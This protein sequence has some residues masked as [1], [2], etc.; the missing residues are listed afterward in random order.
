MRGSISSNATDA[1]KWEATTVIRIAQTNRNAGSGS[2]FPAHSIPFRNR[3][4]SWEELAGSGEIV[5][6][7]PPVREKKFDE[8][9]VE[10]SANPP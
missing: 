6:A 2:L 3:C 7:E 8:S 9:L 10:F 4:I 1:R 5:M